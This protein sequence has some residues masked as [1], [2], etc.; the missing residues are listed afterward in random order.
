MRAAAPL[1]LLGIAVILHGDASAQDKSKREL[2]IME[3]PR[4]NSGKF[5]TD[6]IFDTNVWVTLTLRTPR[7]GLGNF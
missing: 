1:L 2:T 4:P 5:T 3:V 6:E 7:G